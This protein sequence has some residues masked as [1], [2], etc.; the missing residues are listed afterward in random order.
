MKTEFN[1]INLRE[2]IMVYSF[3]FSFFKSLLFIFSFC[4]LGGY[5][6]HHYPYLFGLDKRQRFLPGVAILSKGQSRALRKVFSSSVVF[7]VFC[8]SKGV[9][10]GSVFPY[11]SDS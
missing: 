2:K 6:A 1:I 10:R 5:K 9:I 3:S 7:T 8:F 4:L 11:S